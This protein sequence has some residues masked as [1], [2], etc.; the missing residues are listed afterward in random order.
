MKIGIA[1]DNYKLNKF[2]SALNDAGFAD[3]DVVPFVDK[4]SVITVDNVP[5]ERVHDIHKLCRKLQI[6]FK[7]SN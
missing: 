5:K 4:T 6:D 3:L 2:K 1:V 7:H